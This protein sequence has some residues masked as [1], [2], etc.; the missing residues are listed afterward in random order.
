MPLVPDFPVVSAVLVVGAR[1]TLIR[2]AFADPREVAAGPT[3][4]LIETLKRK[5]LK[6]DSFVWVIDPSSKLDA[7]HT[8]ATQPRNLL[9][10]ADANAAAQETL[11]KVPQ[12]VCRVGEFTCWVREAGD[13]AAPAVAVPVASAFPER[14][15][16]EAAI[17]TCVLPAASDTAVAVIGYTRGNHG[18]ARSPLRYAL[19]QPQQG[20]G[21]R[22]DQ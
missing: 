13:G 10:A 8:V 11:D 17:R 9:G 19:L 16:I 4:Q 18:W 15:E 3:A 1:A 2:V 7:A 21:D 12:Y 20:D 5:G 22:E 14:S 6:V